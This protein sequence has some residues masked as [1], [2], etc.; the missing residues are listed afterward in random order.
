MFWIHGSHAVRFKEGYE[1][2]AHKAKIDI[3]DHRGDDTLQAVCNWLQD[4]SQRWFIVL[5]NADTENVFFHPSEHSST[6]ETND[7]KKQ[8]R[9]AEY[10]PRT[11]NGTVLI[12]ARDHHVGVRFTTRVQ[13]V[14]RIG[15]MKEQTAVDL[16]E[17]KLGERF[18]EQEGKAL[19]NAL[20][21][22]P[23][24]LTQASA[25][26]CQMAHEVCTANYLMALKREDNGARY[27]RY[28]NPNARRDAQVRYSV[29]EAWQ[30]SFNHIRVARPSA[31][32]LLSLLCNVFF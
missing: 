15:T 25:F 24:V 14:C 28:E 18:K 1:A 10:I 19:A 12:T 4:T 32:Q 30:L 31:A 21:C 23:L 9:L 22:M 2:I 5:D 26:I 17:R 11:H 29:Y 20:E 13:D 6:H 3:Q 7:D 8:K 16:L 27:H